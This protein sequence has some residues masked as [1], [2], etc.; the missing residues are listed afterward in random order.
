MPPRQLVFSASPVEVVFHIYDAPQTAGAE[1]RI[2]GEVLGLD[3]GAVCT[4][5]LFH[6]GNRIDSVP[7]DDFGEFSF[8]VAEPALYS[9][10]LII[11]RKVIDIG[12]FEIGDP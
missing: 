9:L 4:V 8:G 1:A 10:R 2:E 5:D 12:P 6:A 3:D 11:G 7:C